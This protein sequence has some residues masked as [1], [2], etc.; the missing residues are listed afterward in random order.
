MFS[1]VLKLPSKNLT[2]E[3][4]YELPFFHSQEG[5]ADVLIKYVVI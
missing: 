1:L 2:S 5:L 3:E 4:R